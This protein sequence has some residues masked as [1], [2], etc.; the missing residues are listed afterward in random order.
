MPRDYGRWFHY[1][2][3]IRPARPQHPQHDLKEPMEATQHRSPMFPLQHSDLLPQGEHLQR[4]IQ[5]TA[6]E[7]RE[8]GE[9]CADYVDHKS[10]LP[11]RDGALGHSWFAAKPLISNIS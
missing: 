6:K 3:N 8:G 2:Q 7:N 1:V 9:N 10:A 5:A 4:D 11:C